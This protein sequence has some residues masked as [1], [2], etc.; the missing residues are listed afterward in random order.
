MKAVE[1]ELGII[2]KYVGTR[3][4]KPSGQAQQ[5]AWSPD[6]GHQGPTEFY[7]FLSHLHLPSTAVNDMDIFREEILAS[8][9]KTFLYSVCLE[10]YKTL[11]PALFFR[12]LHDR[13]TEG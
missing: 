9:I 7:D 1:R 4:G 5:A 3:A 6:L 13:D 8:F 12:P 11:S 2:T 10:P